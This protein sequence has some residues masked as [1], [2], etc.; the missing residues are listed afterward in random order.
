[1]LPTPTIP[2][3]DAVKWCT[4]NN[5][6]QGIRQSQNRTPLPALLI[7]AAIVAEESCQEKSIAPKTPAKCETHNNQP[8]GM[9]RFQDCSPLPAGHTKEQQHHLRS[10]LT[11]QWYGTQQSTAKHAA[12]FAISQCKLLEP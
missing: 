2:C 12:N 5:Q 10:K 8:R 11:P 4:H 6:P 9:Q 3:D 7:L 1:V